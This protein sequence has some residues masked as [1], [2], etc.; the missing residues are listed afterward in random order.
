MIESSNPILAGVRSL[1]Q[2][3]PENGIVDDVQERADGVPALV[4]KPHLEDRKAASLGSAP[5]DTLHEQQLFKEKNELQENNGSRRKVL[6]AG[7]HFMPDSN[8]RRGGI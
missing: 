7:R 8:R 1:L 4:V 2:I 6:A 5:Q 3:G